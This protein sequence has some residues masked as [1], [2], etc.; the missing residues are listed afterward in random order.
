M[1]SARSSCSG[2]FFHCEQSKEAGLGR[3]ELG[4]AKRCGIQVGK[5]LLIFFRNSGLRQTVRKRNGENKLR[6]KCG[7]SARN[8]SAEKVAGNV[9][10]NVAENGAENIAEN[11]AEKITIR[12]LLIFFSF[13]FS[14]LIFACGI[15]MFACGFFALFFALFFAHFYARIFA[16]FSRTLFPKV[17]SHF[18]FRI[19]L[20]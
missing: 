10:E 17:F 14:A 20:L 16:C 11:N 5:K 4:Y 18:I 2:R 13:S 6:K 19:I 15:L 1:L 12:F 8:K 3:S 9:A 7:K